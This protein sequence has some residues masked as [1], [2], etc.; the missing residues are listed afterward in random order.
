MA[1]VKRSSSALGSGCL[2]LFALPFAAVGV[3]V[4]VWLASTL[5][6]YLSARSWV[7][8]PAQIIR[9]D[10]KVSRGKSTSYQVTA[11]YAYEFGGRKYHG[12]RVGLTGGYDNFGSFQQDAYRELDQHKRSK[13]P[14]RCFV[15]PAQPGEA[16]LYRQLRW[17][18][19]AFQM[20]F[21]LVFGTVGFGLLIGGSMSFAS[22]R[23]EARL[24][25]DHPD[26]PWMWKADWAAGRIVS[27]TKKSMVASLIIALYWN[28][29]TLPLWFVLPGEII[30]RRN[31]WAL[32]GLIFPAIG[33]LLIWWAIYCLLRWRK[34]GQSEFQ[35]ADVPGVIGGQLGGVIR[36]SAKIRPEDG[37]HLHLRC[38]RRVT[39]GS[40]KQ[41]TT[42]ESVRWENE[43]TVMHEL[44]EDQAELSAI[45]VVFSI[46]GDCWPSDSLN[47]D[48]Q[49]IWRLTASARVP[50]I[51]YS[52]TFEV[53]VFSI[54][55]A[56]QG[57][58]V[59]PSSA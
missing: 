51:H 18:M 11:E 15:N 1:N 39:T 19:A 7:E 13:K 16:V 48:D 24:A 47:A 6:T 45:P 31:G 35:M 22:Q 33:L 46:A 53:P 20:I 36:T 42:S 29:V 40:G 25:A 17:E 14:F 57:D 30:D 9:T 41:R 5:L 34:F 32:L 10:L 4:G 54:K 55:S 49:T 50:G 26:S 21:V 38:V 28:V 43:Q 59:A 12:N 27:S 44:L 56:A 23:T 2:I 37:F 58:D 8:T 3:G 52:A